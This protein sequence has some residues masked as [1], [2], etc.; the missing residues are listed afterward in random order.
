M[1]AALAIAR[2]TTRQVLGPRRLLIGAGL[3]VVPP[4]VYFVS[5]VSL[6]DAAAAER[7]IEFAA[8]IYFPLV[9]PITA[10]I[11]GAAALGDERRDETLSFVVLRPLSRF[12]IAAAKV[13]AAAGAAVV[14][15]AVGAIGLGLAFGLA[16][17]SWAL[18]LPLLIGGAVA[19][20]GYTALFV[21]LGYLVER[22]VI[23]GL[24][25]VAIWEN[26]LVRALPDLST[27]SPWRIGF[28]ASA[29]LIPEDAS[30]DLPE[31]AIGSLQPGAGGAFLKVAVL[32]GLSVLFIGWLLRTRDLV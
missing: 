32:T 2:M 4:L 3:E 23:V 9:V 30:I 6:T 18:V 5:A 14:L 1:T 7:L 28:S 26:G 27:L 24:V 29:A 17:G 19:T 31:F 13:A 20:L 12:S 8:S 16:T 25:F 11:V 15:N 22:A 21:P 10:L